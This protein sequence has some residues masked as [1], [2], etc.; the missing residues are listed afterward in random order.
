MKFWRCPNCKRERLFD[1]ELVMK[2][3]PCGCEME[4]VEDGS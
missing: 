2:I 3:C 1:M 4:V